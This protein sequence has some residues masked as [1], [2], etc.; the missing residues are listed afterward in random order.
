[1]VFWQSFFYL[2]GLLLL[3][4]DLKIN[5]KIPEASAEVAFLDFAQDF[6]KSPIPGDK[7]PQM[8]KILNLQDKNPQIFGNP[9]SP[10]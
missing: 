9:K 3:G 10:G 1:M 8:L 7:N 4:S 5:C 6:Q 2:Y